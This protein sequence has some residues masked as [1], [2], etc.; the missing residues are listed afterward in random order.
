[1]KK[2][3]LESAIKYLPAM[4]CLLTSSALWAQQEDY[5]PLAGDY[6]FLAVKNLSVTTTRVIEYQHLKD[7]D[8][9][10][11]HTGLQNFTMTIFNCTAIPDDYV[12][13]ANPAFTYE[14]KD[15]NGNIVR[16]DTDNLT[17]F[18]KQPQFSA[19]VKKDIIAGFAVVR[20]GR[21]KLTAEI[22]PGLFSYETELT[23]PSEPDMIIELWEESKGTAL[24]PELTLTS[25]YPYE[26]ADFAGV[27]HLHWTLTEAN[28]PQT[29]IAE[30]DEEFELKSDSPSLAAIATLKLEFGDKLK[31]G[32]YACKVTS[33]DFAPANY[34]FE[35]IVNDV[36]LPQISLDKTIYRVP[37]DKEA[38]VTVDMSY[39]Y[40]YVG[41]PESGEPTVTVSAK[42][43]DDVTTEE[44]KD[45]A[46]A[47][48]EMHCTATLKVP[49][50]KVTADIVKE[51][52]GKV[53][54]EVTVNFN[55]RQAYQTQLEL[56]F[57]T[58]GT[59]IDGITADD[60]CKPDVR[61]Y[62]VFGLEVNSSY[63]GIVI[64]SDGHKI[65][66]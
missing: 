39:G 11:L 17:S 36:L 15:L 35:A 41:R 45:E 42:L 52:D 10:G 61:Y 13:P 59:G 51:D 44:Y 60:G 64:T 58:D 66:R 4:L 12:A 47:E 9:E 57:E 20:G 38:V 46:W 26:A 22:T 7:W 40:P 30:K 63:R 27:K 37:E 34:T 32:K 55:G 33:A 54:L 18:F 62:N 1:M 25:G 19:N 28:D 56:P 43:Y 48:G 21:Y 3:Y 50:D 6:S 16:Q 24:T 2:K 29:I 14:I 31:P 53:P 23:F 49:L 65:I 5:I 8:G